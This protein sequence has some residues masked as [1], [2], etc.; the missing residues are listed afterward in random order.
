MRT[1]ALFTCVIAAG[2][3]VGA[4]AATEVIHQ[5]GRVF[6]TESISVKKGDAV[7]FLNDDTVPHNIMSAT[8]GNEFNLG[9]QA[10]GTSTDVTFKE[11]GDVQVICAIHPR[12][13]MMVKVTD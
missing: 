11:A 7:T 2:F 10:P 8:K 9:S 4:Y 6:S 12:M 1:I 5:Q 13:K 3:S